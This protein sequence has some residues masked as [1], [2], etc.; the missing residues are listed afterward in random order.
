MHL[1]S[2]YPPAATRGDRTRLRLYELLDE[3][4]RR[5]TRLELVCWQFNLD[6]SRARPAWDV[7]LRIGLIA[8]AG[9]DRHTGEAVFGLTDRGH[10]ARRALR[11]TRRR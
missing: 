11:A 10:R 6:E 8:P 7:A 3:V 9:S 5:P 2:R 1:P 4:S